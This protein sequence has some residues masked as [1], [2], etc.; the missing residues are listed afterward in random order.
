MGPWAL[1]SVAGASA[2]ADRVTKEVAVRRL[3]PGGSG[4]LR[5]VSNKRLPLAPQSSRRV[6]VTQWVAALACA[7]A[8][9]ATAPT[10][11]A[12]PLATVGLSLALGGALSNLHD[13]VARGGVVDF[14]A[15]GR[16]PVFNVADVAIVAG[17]LIATA[18]IV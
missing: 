3:V 11:R 14:I 9:F 13:R 10:M 1:L 17:A 4:V 15:I 16:W 18:S 2:L 8:A 5:L 12:D 6:L 7:A